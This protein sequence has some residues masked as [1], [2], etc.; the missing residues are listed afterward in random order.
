MVLNKYALLV[1][2]STVLLKST[3]KCATKHN[4]T[5]TMQPTNAVP[6]IKEKRSLICYF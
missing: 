1:Y 5:A 3:I 6:T 2:L 4:L